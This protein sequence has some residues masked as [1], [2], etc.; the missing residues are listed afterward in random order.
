MIL[1]YYFNDGKF[2]IYSVVAL[3]CGFFF[4]RFTVGKLVMLV[5]EAILFVLR[6]AVLT[7]FDWIKKP[8][9]VFVVFFGKIAKKIAKK[10]AKSI[11]KKRKKVY[12]NHNSRSLLREAEKGFL[13]KDNATD[14]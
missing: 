10:L 9:G 3:L 14:V 1:N 5:L 13:H 8:M 12:N 2:R 11:A 6:A 7:L 4:Y